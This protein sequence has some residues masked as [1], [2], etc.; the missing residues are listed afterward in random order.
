MESKGTSL[1]NVPRER[2][3]EEV[4][5]TLLKNINMWKQ[6]KQKEEGTS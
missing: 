5:H 2:M 1:G 3:K 4:K 6:N